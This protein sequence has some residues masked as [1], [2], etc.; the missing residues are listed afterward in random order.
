VP[1][2]PAVVACQAPP[3]GYKIDAEEGKHIN[4]DDY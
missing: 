3:L 2:G 4:I 1:A